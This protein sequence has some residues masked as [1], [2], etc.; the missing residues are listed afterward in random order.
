MLVVI[1]ALSALTLGAVLASGYKKRSNKPNPV[2]LTPTRRGLGDSVVPVDTAGAAGQA[3]SSLNP[4]TL[5]QAWM[6]Q[7]EWTT[8]GAGN[9]V[10]SSSGL[11]T[12]IVLTGGSASTNPS[13]TWSATV[14]PQTS[15][16]PLQLGIIIY[17]SAALTT[18]AVR[19][20]T[21][22]SGAEQVISV[23]PGQTLSVTFAGVRA[24]TS[25]TVAVDGAVQFQQGL[26]AVPWAVGVYA[27]N[28]QSGAGAAVTLA[29]MA[30]S[31]ASQ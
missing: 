26:P 28:L 1:V 31:L 13:A 12:D 14:S 29:D 2:A 15:T 19:V 6:G 4:P 21:A 17:N 30:V 23:Q 24:Q 10:G 22:A 8:D 25:V 3:L 7:P 11:V 5:V 27:G 9:A 18:P 20:G 16:T